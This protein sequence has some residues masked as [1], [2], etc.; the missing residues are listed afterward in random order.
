MT[1]V[2][3]ILKVCDAIFGMLAKHILD[4]FLG[5]F[6]G[7]SGQFIGSKNGKESWPPRNSRLCVLPA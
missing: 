2:L 4:Y 5:F 3:R 6:E 1:N 7:D